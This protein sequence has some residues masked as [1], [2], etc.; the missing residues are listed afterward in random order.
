MH[1]TSINNGVI[2]MAVQPKTLP[3]GSLD[4]PQYLEFE[5]AGEEFD[6]WKNEW[7][8]RVELYYLTR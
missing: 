8:K 4:T 5:V 1:G 7:N 6:H 2:L 3:D